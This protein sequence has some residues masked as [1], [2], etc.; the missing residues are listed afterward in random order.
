MDPKE[1]GTLFVRKGVKFERIQEGGHQEQSKRTGTENVAGIV[2]LGKAIELADT[3][4]E[5]YNKKLTEL[6]DYQE[7]LILLFNSWKEKHYY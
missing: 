3:E 6:R 4:F 1:W 2:G 7:M 5:Q